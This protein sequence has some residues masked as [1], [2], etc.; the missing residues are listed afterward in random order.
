MY[1]HTAR[2]SHLKDF[3]L[4]PS[5]SPYHPNHLQHHLKEKAAALW[6]KTWHVTFT[7]DYFPQNLNNKSKKIIRHTFTLFKPPV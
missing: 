5:L 2:N 6:L 3:L 1:L 4:T 7:I